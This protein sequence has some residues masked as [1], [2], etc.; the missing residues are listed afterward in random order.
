MQ[1]T[2]PVLRP[3]AL[4]LAAALGASSVWAQ[5]T[6]Q[7]VITGNPLQRDALSQP[8]SVLA[9]EGLVLRRAATLGDTLD[10]LPGVASTWFGPNSGRPVIRGLDGDR[11]RLLDNGGAS[12]DAS[13]LSFDH[14][15]AIDPLVIE[16][17]EVLRGPAALLYGGNATGGVVNTLDNRIPRQVADGLSGRAELRLGG[18]ADER[19]L[20]ALLEGGSGGLAWHVDG[21]S[22][23][24][25]DL[26]VPRHVPTVDGESLD[27]TTRVRNSAAKS[28]GGAVGAGWVGANGYLG[29]SIDTFRSDYGVTVED[30]VTIRMKRDRVSA[31]GQWRSTGAWRDLSFQAS[32]TDYRHQEVEGSGEVGTTFDSRGRELRLQARHAPLTALAG[33]EGVVGLQFESLGFSALGEEAFVPGTRTRNLGFF[34][35]ESFR[36]GAVEL[37]G[38]L[39]HERVRVAS[40]GDDAAAEA[41]RFGAAAER[42]FSPTSASLGAVW[43]VAP[44]WQARAGLG[45]TERAPAYYELYAD[46]LHL[47]TAAFEVGDPTL[48]V[49]RSVNAEV[50]LAWTQG[51]HE[52]SVNA[53]TT[54]FSNYIAL[55]ATGSDRPVED[56]ETGELGSVPEY[57]FRGVRARLSGLEVEA[58]TGWSLAGWDWQLSGGLD[59]V[60][61]TNRD[62]SEPLPRIAPVR[63]RVALETTIGAWRM[64]LGVHHAARQNRVPSTDTATAGH[65]RVD[66]SASWRQRLGGADAL[67]FVS[68]RNLGDTLAYQAT[69]IGTLRGLVPLPGRSLAAG[70]QM[71]F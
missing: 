4:A 24:S 40:D 29:M 5:A 28:D 17:I 60:R 45:R 47:A 8:A 39:R 41:P 44:G 43:R 18:A 62:T 64:A 7:V 67:W 19:S 13:S 6:Q 3:L 55:D 50:G 32:D 36:V 15:V 66:L 11:V 59:L 31:A 49:E 26:R 69:T 33:L 52:V 46:G 16:R 63:A 25:S 14:A 54:D 20:G 65:T 2:I 56:E 12:V 70:V 1:S 35:L 71:A 9:G 34:V 57:R 22:R 53:F 21:F 61:G 48:A 37:S 42:R 38:G 10:G 58:R 51:R 30:E 23:S 27:P 68:A